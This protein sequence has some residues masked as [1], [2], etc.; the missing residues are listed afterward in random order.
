[1]PDE[2]KKRQHLFLGDSYSVKSKYKRPPQ[3]FSTPEIPKQQRQAHGDKL[4]S[5]LNVIKRDLLSA[6]EIQKK[7]GIM[8]D[9]G[10][11]IEIESFEGFERVF[12]DLTYNKTGIELLCIRHE[13]NKTYATVFVP[14]GK[15]VYFENQI[16]AYLK[17]KKRI[18][19]VPLDNQKLI[20]TIQSIHTATLRALWT[21]TL[22]EYP[23]NE[24][25]KIWWEVWL[26]IRD[27]RKRV[28]DS[29][30]ELTRK[31]QMLPSESH[32]NFPQRTVF[33]LQASRKEMEKSILLMNSIAELRRAKETADFFTSLRPGEQREWVDDLIKRL[34][35][36]DPNK[37]IPY[38]CVLDTGM[39]NA[40]PLLEELIDNPDLLTI[41]PKW[42]V[43]DNE[44]HGT[45]VAG[46]ALYGDLTD[47]IV[48]SD[49]IQISHKIESVKI[50]NKNGSN[51][52]NE[53]FHASLTNQAVS[54][55]IVNN[56]TRIR[57]FQLAIT[58]KDY[59]DKGRPSAWSS[60]ID[61]MSFNRD[62]DNDSQLFVISGGNIEGSENWSQYPEI[63]DQE[64]IHDP[65]QAWNA[66]TVGAYTE[67]VNITETGAEDYIPV[68]EKGALS[69]FSSTSHSWESQWPIKP[70]IVM[71]GGNVAKTHFG[72]VTA[73]SLSL[74]TVN[75]I[76]SKRLFSSIWATSASS[77]LASNLA[78]KVLSLYPNMRAETL[79]GLIV[80]SANW[81]DEMKKM[82][83][84]DIPSANKGSYTN[85][86]RHC[87]F[88]VP[89]TD[90]VLWTLKNSLT[91]II[92]DSLRPFDKHSDSVNEMRFHTL[93]WPKEK[94]LELG[95]QEVEMRVTLSYF[96]EPNPSS[97]G[98]S[99]YTYQSHGLRFD[100]NQ[101]TEDINQ[102]K[103]RISAEYREADKVYSK[104]PG[105]DR[106]C[107]GID[108]RHRGSL[109]S[110][111]WRGPA[112][113]LALTNTLAVYPVVGWWKK[114]V[115]MKQMN[116]IAHY[117]LL[118]SLR[119]PKINVDLLTPIVNQI[120][121]KIGTVVTV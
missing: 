19:G 92:E 98:R 38:I 97:R 9:Y 25:D 104:E 106:W 2:S 66:L 121:T 76:P 54:R 90:T 107:L 29:F 44:G 67:K 8:L 34:K 73:D 96:I 4:L 111:I 118:V 10:L 80:H 110:D 91:M 23:S 69:P 115:A 116:S 35:F 49:S 63:N 15:L 79:R 5:D 81:T 40:H 87:G 74:L 108:A 75:H 39:N 26:T 61:M 51:T 72:A 13:N 20:D 47:S 14:D 28:I 105:A 42:G 85:L 119:A 59:R 11:Q 68:A 117:T 12:E 88:G 31:S 1:M 78:A 37:T 113:E 30:L 112:A 18:D 70:D 120:A 45:A 17:E 53:H 101:R 71:E 16:K 89:D 58:A 7:S 83:L 64:A 93:P 84:G 52:S 27:D 82:Y 36:P 77:A 22:S 48:S 24:N 21:D 50:L 94:L 55:A 33:V 102:F 95:S 56:P 43:N 86:V 114:N 41:E 103:G 32:I 46:A 3:S 62:S 60:V 6:V 99:R 109:H 57:L 100:V 65:G